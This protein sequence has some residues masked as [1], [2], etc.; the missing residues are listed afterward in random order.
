MEFRYGK[1]ELG[2]IQ[3][4]HLVDIP[5]PLQARN[6]LVST[7]RVEPH[8]ILP[9]SGWV[10]EEKNECVS[11]GVCVGEWKSGRVE[12]WKLHRS[13]EIAKNRNQVRDA[14]R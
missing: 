3:G 10:R 6:E 5:F 12:E 8:H 1:R 11:G 14:S 9:Q 2:L 13:Y 4:N 7:G